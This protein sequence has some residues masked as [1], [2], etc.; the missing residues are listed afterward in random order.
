MKIL[1][2]CI[3]TEEPTMRNSRL[4]TVLAVLPQWLFV[5]Y[6]IWTKPLWRQQHVFESLNFLMDLIVRLVP[7]KEHASV[8]VLAYFRPSSIQDCVL[9]VDEDIYGVILTYTST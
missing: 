3:F 7:A 6:L 4:N 5:N 9:Q 8:D 1:Y 2:I